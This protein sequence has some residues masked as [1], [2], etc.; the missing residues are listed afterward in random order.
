MSDQHRHDLRQIHIAAAADADD[1]VRLKGPGPFRRFDRNLDGRLGGPFVK[2]MGA[3]RS[4][5]QRL[6]DLRGDACSD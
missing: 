6:H 4:L 1:A 3:E 2:E 5:G